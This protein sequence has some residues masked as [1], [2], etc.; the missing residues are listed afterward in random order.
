MAVSPE[1]AKSSVSSPQ[2]EVA[3]LA[4]VNFARSRIMPKSIWNEHTRRALLERLERLAPEARPRWGKMTAPQ[5]VAHLMNWARMAEGEVTTKTIPHPLRYTPL[6]QLVIYWLPWPKGVPTAPELVAREPEE[7]EAETA[8]LRA[9]IGSFDTADAKAEWP[10]HPAFGKL[11]PRAW[12]VLCYR[13]I[14]HH[15]RQFGV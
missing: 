10:L 2:S 1:A 3:Y 4:R 6:K 7:W 8:A 12:G 9:H 14:D 13:H 5:M 15:F 11:T